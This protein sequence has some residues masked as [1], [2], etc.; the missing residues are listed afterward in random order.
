M[1]GRTEINLGLQQD[2]SVLDDLVVVAFGTQDKATVTGSI[3]SI[4]TAEIKQSPAANLAV[5]LTGRLPGLI[6]IQQSGEPGQDDPLMY[7]RGRSTLNGQNPII[8]VDGIERDL[9]YIDPNEVESVTILKDAS[10]TALFGVRGANGVVLV[11]TRRGVAGAPRIN[12]S[13]EHGFQDFTRTP[14]SLDSYDWALLRNEA[15]QNNHPGVDPN[16]PVNQPPFSDYALERYR[17]QDNPEAY[18]NND[19]HSLLMHDFVA[20]SR[21]NLSLSG[22]GDFAQYFVNVGHL[23]QGGQWKVEEDHGYDP[24]SFLNRSNFR[25]NIDAKLNESGTLTTFLNAAGYL[26]K[27]N[28]PNASVGNILRF[29]NNQ[30]PSVLAG[31]LAP[32]GEVLTGVGFEGIYNQS[33]Y[34]MINRSGYRQQTRSNIAASWGL[35]QDLS[36]IVTEGLS[37]K[38]MGSFDT[39]SVHDLVGN[40]NY[41]SWRQDII[42]ENEEDIVTY[43]NADVTQ[44][45]TPL[46]TSTSSAFDS[47]ANFQFML[48]YNTIFADR[49]AVTGLLMGQQE[50]RIRSND[51]LPFNLRGISSRITYGYD[52]RYHFE[53]NAGFNGS[54]QFAESRRYG[55]FPSVSAGWVLS[56]ENFLRNNSTLS[57]LK[58]RGSYG[59][60][61]GDQ[62]GGRRFLYLDEIQRQ[63]GGG[64]SGSLDQGGYIDEAFIGNPFV[65]WE[66]A[67]KANLGLEIGLFEQLDLLIDVFDERRDNVLINLGTVPQLYGLPLNRLAP[68][69]LGSVNNRGYE[70]ELNHRSFI[71]RDLYIVSRLNFNHNTNEVTNS[72]ELPR[73]EDYAHRYRT[74]GY[75]I[76]QYFGYVRDGFYGSQ[77]EID[78]SGLEYLVA[79]PRPGDFRYTDVNEDGIIDNRDV[80]PLG[81]STVPEYTFGTAFNVNYKGFDI[82]VLFQGVFNVSRNFGDLGVRELQTYRDRHT[83][84]WTAERAAA[85]ERIDYPA[86]NT[87]IGYSH[88]SN[89]FFLENTS[90]VRLKNIEVGYNLPARWLEGKARSIRLYANGLNLFTWDKMRTK[91][92]DPEITSGTTYPVYRVINTGVNI[93]F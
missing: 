45:N 8:L 43:T 84:A 31:P 36:S 1:D 46:S 54:E 72:D 29:I 16:D 70:I 3:A 12:Y 21:H 24:S 37:A 30:F 65:Q 11:T 18:P 44:E 14:S 55:F 4:R 92:F 93:Q 51:R 79:T 88:Q 28:S 87:D 20:Q 73:P 25:S 7:L 27:V 71:N 90:Y 81:Y 42:T 68:Q 19:W 82:S 6:T 64:Y 26:E 39:R 35:E 9:G 89:D 85:G 62:L 17:L 5:T 41:E 66:V 76:G 78:N 52:E 23:N 2:A 61:G 13:Y 22:G 56:N 15:W 77:E 49:H 33:P 10:S 40:K 47:F 75:S 60:V 48:N 86:L 63:G 59:T 38:F 69:N 50:S 57:F 67:K 53:I 74:E 80:V 91:D 34:G 83:R 58:L 32:N